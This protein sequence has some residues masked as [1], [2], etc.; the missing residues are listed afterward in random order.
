MYIDE[1]EFR[2]IYKEN[3]IMNVYESIYDVD[4]IE[5]YKIKKK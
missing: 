3:V 2:Y 4:R 1:H 5:K